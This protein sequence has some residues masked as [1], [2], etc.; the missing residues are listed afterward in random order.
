MCISRERGGIP[1]HEGNND[2]IGEVCTSHISPITSAAMPKAAVGVTVLPASV[3][4][5]A[6]PA[7][8]TM[9]P[10]RAEHPPSWSHCKREHPQPAGRSRTRPNAP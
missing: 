6:N 9:Q 3:T 4:E 8:R 10:I 1:F 7:A 5:P 2:I